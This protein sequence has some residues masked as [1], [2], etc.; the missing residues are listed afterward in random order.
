[1]SKLHH[2]SPS[3][4]FSSHIITNIK[5]GHYQKQINQDTIG[6]HII[7]INK[8]TNQNK[9][10]QKLFKKINDELDKAELLDIDL[11]LESGG[12]TFSAALFDPTTATFSTANIGDS[13]IY[14]CF[15]E[16]QGKKRKFL[17]TLTRDDDPNDPIVA[18]EYEE[19][20]GKIIDRTINT[21][22]TK[23][24]V[25][26]NKAIKFLAVAASLADYDVENH[27]RE[28]LILNFTPES[29]A[30]V[31]SEYIPLKLT[32]FFVA[33]DGFC[34]VEN[35]LIQDPS[36]T[37]NNFTPFYKICHLGLNKIPRRDELANRVA[38]QTDFNFQEVTR[39]PFSESTIKAIKNKSKFLQQSDFPHLLANLARIIGSKD[40]ITVAFTN[41]E[42]FY[43]M[44]RPSGGSSEKDMIL[45]FVCDGHGPMGHK[46]A[47][48]ISDAISKFVEK[49][50][51]KP[52]KAV[53][54]E[55]PN[56]KV[57]IGYA[58][59][60]LATDS[61]NIKEQCEKS[62]RNFQ[63]KIS[64]H[65]PE[66][67]DNDYLENCEEFQRDYEKLLKNIDKLDPKKSLTKISEEIIKLHS[68]IAIQL[69]ANDNPILLNTLLAKL[70][71]K[72]KLQE[73][74]QEHSKDVKSKQDFAIFYKQ[75]Q[76]IDALAK[77]ESKSATFQS[78][79]EFGLMIKKIIELGMS[80]QPTE[81]K[82]NAAELEFSDFPDLKSQGNVWQD[83]V[84]I[85][86]VT[87]IQPQAELA[88]DEQKLTELKQ[89]Y[90]YGFS[91]IVDIINSPDIGEYEICQVID[92]VTK[93]YFICKEDEISKNNPEFL[94]IMRKQLNKDPDFIE[95]YYKIVD[96]ILGNFF[97]MDLDYEGDEDGQTII[98]FDDSNLE[99]E[100]NKN[101]MTKGTTE[102]NILS[103]IASNAAS[104][105]FSNYANRLNNIMDKYVIQESPSASFHPNPEI[106]DLPPTKRMR[107]S[108]SER[109]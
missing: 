65:L 93:L 67:A 39:I 69:D 27:I 86:N 70:E 38:D 68:D 109:S 48:I 83:M 89:F 60:S 22:T 30:A 63:D 42:K 58:S 99:T 3:D 33:S 92:D 64:K 12:S 9:I 81:P 49:H 21:S 14:C 24:A 13:R 57:S 11:D 104:L 88:S 55:A 1:M 8:P 52:V 32:G 17:V 101:W 6:C 36:A 47:K 20:D 98:T 15:N 61:K 53:A 23:K 71:D 40:D 5:N 31:F 41:L 34:D 106:D 45:S 87:C 84:P 97:K 75:Y 43:T 56:Y 108:E 107:E 85:D 29:A 54:E 90:K 28:P 46:V 62:F 59:N 74:L 35:Y 80:F 51:S 10:W 2:Y 94:P 25:S 76:T 50:N 100:S 26:G 95:N 66:F 19:I 37:P 44:A 77:E 16:I 72:L 79:N 91:N 102:Y 7:K 18:K 78:E 4:F 73:K 96:V 103:R 82:T 105:G